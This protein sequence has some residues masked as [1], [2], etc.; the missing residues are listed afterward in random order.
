MAKFAVG[1]RVIFN[2]D[3]NYCCGK[4]WVGQETVIE[5]VDQSGGE[6]AYHVELGGMYIEEDK[7]LPIEDNLFSAV[8][9]G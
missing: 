7:L 5:S 4:G 8:S 9:N 6:Y 3:C 2:C 1:E